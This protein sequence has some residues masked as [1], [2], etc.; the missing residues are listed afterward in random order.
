[1]SRLPRPIVRSR[2]R[3]FDDP[4]SVK[5]AVRLIIVV[6]VVAV[7]LG[8]LAIWVFDH[9]DFPD[10]GTALWFSLQTV[11]TVG[12]GD[13]TPT[14]IIG[15]LVAGVVMV[16]AIGFIA[17]FTAAVTSTFVEAARSRRGTADEAAR[18]DADER[19]HVR[20]DEIARRLDQIERRLG[21]EDVSPTGTA[22]EGPTDRPP[23]EPIDRA[24]EGTNG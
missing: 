14:T 1:M 9:R 24:D 8:S 19:M 20:F 18:Q 7:L 21:I 17:V 15:R 5:N 22:T 12:Y 3:F 4:S 2:S 13:V 11:T 6:T 23:A 16:T 10:Y